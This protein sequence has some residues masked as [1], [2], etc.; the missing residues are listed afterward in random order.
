MVSDNTIKKKSLFSSL[1]ISIIFITTA[2]LLIISIIWFYDTKTKLTE[3]IKISRQNIINEK[4]GKIKKNVLNLKKDIKF[5]KDNLNIQVKR[6][7]FSKLYEKYV[8][9]QRIYNQYKDKKGDY[10]IKKLIK[11]ILKKSSFANKNNFYYFIMKIDGYIVLSPLYSN[12]ENT[13]P[14]NIQDEDKKYFI[15]DG[16]KL[17]KEKKEGFIEIRIKKQVKNSR[18]KRLQAKQFFY[19]KLFKPY[20][21]II[22]V[23]LYYDDY[24]EYF[25]NS[26]L[27]KLKD[28]DLSKDEY[29]IA[30]SYDGKNLMD[31]KTDYLNKNINSSKK[32][33]NKIEIL[34]R[35]DKVKKSSEGVFFRYK[36]KDK[37]TG[38]IFE[39]IEY[40]I[41]I[42]ELGLIIGSGLN[43][44]NLDIIIGKRR[45]KLNKSIV[46]TIFK[47]IIIFFTL[48]LIFIYSV[49]KIEKKPLMEVKRLTEYFKTDALR[50][51]KID[52][53]KFS[54]KEPTMVAQNLNYLI[55]KFS[56]TTEKLIESE[57]K[58]RN[59]TEQIKSAVY[60]FDKNGYFLYVNSAMVEITGYSKEELSKIKFFELIHPEFKK[61]VK[62]RGEKR[63][64]GKKVIDTYEFKIITK[65]GD[66]KWVQISNRKI[67]RDN[68][69]LILGTAMD[70]TEGKKAEEL[71]I[72]SEEKFRKIFEN[73]SDP[74]CLVSRKG[75]FDCNKASYEML[76]IKDKEKLFIHPGE[77]SPEKQP[78][79]SNSL[80]KAREII[81]EVYRVGS[82]RFEWV[83]KRFDGEEFWADISLTLIPYRQ[84]KIIFVLWRDISEKK[85]LEQKL[86]EE[87]ERLAVTLRSIGDGII[88]VDT[89]GKIVLMNKV[90]EKLTG[91]RFEEAK[92]K[93]IHEVFN[94]MDEQPNGKIKNSIN[95]VMKSGKIVKLSKDTI[96]IRKNGEKRN[97]SDSA[98]PIKDNKSNIIGAVIVFR[99]ITENLKIEN[100]LQKAQKLESL[101]LVAGGI[102]HDFN[103]LLAGIL[104]N[105]SIAK[106]KLKVGDK[107]YEIL[108]RTE[109]V[110]Y[111]AKGLSNQLLTFSKGGEPIFKKVDI[112]GII[113]DSV[114]FATR[115]TNIKLSVK[116]SKDL[117]YVNADIGQ[118]NQ[119]I[120]NLVINAIQAVG[121]NGKIDVIANNV[122][123][124]HGNA[125]LI[126]PGNYVQIIIKDNGIGI[127]EDILKKIFDPFF[128]TKSDGTG[129]GLSTSYSII[130]KHY[131][132][133]KVISEKNKGTTFYIYLP[134]LLIKKESEKIIS[135]TI[136]KTGNIKEILVVDDDNHVREVAKDMLKMLGYNVI[137]AE[138]G[139][140]AIKIYK[141]KLKT[142][143]K[144]DI[145]IMDLTIPGGMSGEKAVKEILKIDPDVKCIISS[146]YSSGNI[147]S[148][149]KDY[150]FIDVLIKPYKIEELEEVLNRV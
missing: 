80:E 68:K 120:N 15:R 22:G 4:K 43:L 49:I 89:K 108:K 65:Q 86:I 37:K 78:D 40:M 141:Q 34:K 82:K 111:E 39:R 12:L 93:L 48:L 63:L 55:G 27:K 88:A 133:I 74:M 147:M 28:N 71:L 136:K 58:F 87:K 102:A 96:L 148:N 33:S 38:K 14:L 6:E 36:I 46:K 146:G 105:I 104:G 140:E 112:K 118:I 77:V 145:I 52:I 21:W 9:I 53:S 30:L 64:S 16:I 90:A 128:T 60:T 11:D 59:F 67:K 69:F 92:N 83:H 50:Y 114:K 18:K 45:D 42:K 125:L 76:R 122:K 126:K 97:I 113:Y 119:V 1:F 137:L 2:V 57:E 35:I 51:K 62:E 110:V 31:D 98:A 23:S 81:E 116:I 142:K 103:N 84:E 149:Y 106:Q 134:A 127:K 117:H 135:R 124:K 17:I 70:I 29:F 47:T 5:Q 131:G 56:E 72:E 109:T 44:K 61:T 121:E 54:F 3:E 13:K 73:S 32:I 85:M 20:N 26:I 75:F 10:K 7:L 79:G 100:E 130:K 8:L 139:E 19:I 129:L 66:I 94:I 95:D 41:N 99:D 132:E 138:S 123:I 144:I 143:Q 150:G 24:K 25:I 101:A 115:G 107:L 91:W